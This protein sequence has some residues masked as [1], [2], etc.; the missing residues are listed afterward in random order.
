ML[1]ATAVALALVRFGVGRGG[2]FAWIL[3]G[4]AIAGML[5]WALTRPD[6]NESTKN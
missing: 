5:V 2:G 6:R 3:L 4:L 1:T